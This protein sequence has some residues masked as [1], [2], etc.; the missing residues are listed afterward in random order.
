MR[1]FSDS[2][3]EF[4]KIGFLALL[5]FTVVFVSVGRM[6]ELFGIY[7]NTAADVALIYTVCGSFVSY[8]AASASDNKINIAKNGFVD[9][10]GKEYESTDGSE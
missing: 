4:K 5:I 9:R 1:I 3:I 8:C 7:V 2:R 10:L 6:S